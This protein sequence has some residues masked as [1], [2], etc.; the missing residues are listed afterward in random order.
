MIFL[1]IRKQKFY[2]PKT[3]CIKI[4]NITKQKIAFLNS[5]FMIKIF[6]FKSILNILE[7]Y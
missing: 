6:T 4:K 5:L 2:I 3:K 1:Q 7:Y